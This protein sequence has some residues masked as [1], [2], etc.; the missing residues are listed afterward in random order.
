LAILP[1]GLAKVTREGMCRYTFH[2][3]KEHF[4]C[5]SCKKTFKHQMWKFERY[6]RPQEARSDRVPLCPQ[7][8]KPMADMGL[9]FRAPRQND[10]KQWRKVALI[11]RHGITFHGCGCGGDERPATLAEARVFVENRRRTTAGSQ[12]LRRIARR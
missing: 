10:H 2:Y 1:E 3:Y 6:A 11:Y 4:A 12:L 9:D 5:L 8:R 7:C